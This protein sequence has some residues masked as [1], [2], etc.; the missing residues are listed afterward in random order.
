MFEKLSKINVNIILDFYL[1][2]F[3]QKWFAMF[4]FGYLGNSK[5]TTPVPSQLNR[6][7]ITGMQIPAT[8]YQPFWCHWQTLGELQ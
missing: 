3:T 2:V 7:H 1:L 5:L 4:K 8:F 6:F